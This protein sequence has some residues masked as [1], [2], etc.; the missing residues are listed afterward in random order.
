[1]AKTNLCFIGL[2]KNF[3]DNICKKLSAQLEMYY[4]NVQKIIEFELIDIESVEE[5]CGIEYL[6]KEEIKIINRI[7]CFENTLI[8]IEYSNLNNESNL[9]SI[10]DNCLIVY[11]RLDSERFEKEL[12]KDNLTTNQST[13]AKDLFVDRDFICKNISD[14]FINCLDLKTEDIIE[15]I[16]DQILKYYSK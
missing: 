1:M 11:L 14:I 3:T 13:I 2:T 15:I 5:K 6:L 7:S 8:N 16:I 4:A 12:L 9:K 10:R